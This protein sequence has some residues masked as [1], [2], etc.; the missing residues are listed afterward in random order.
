[1]DG[2]VFVSFGF[3]ILMK[4]IFCA[5]IS[6]CSHDSLQMSSLI[7]AE[8]AGSIENPQVAARLG[9]FLMTRKRW[10]FQ[11]QICPIEHRRTVDGGEG[12][13]F[14]CLD[15]GQFR[16]V[17]TQ[18]VNHVDRANVEMALTQIIHDGEIGRL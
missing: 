1:L 9:G 16:H 2:I 12:D 7:C 13:D 11:E 3:L 18:P 5:Y 14:F 15:W 8:T 6:K 17:E 10:L 4:L